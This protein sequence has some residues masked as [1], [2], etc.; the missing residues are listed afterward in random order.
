MCPSLAMSEHATASRTSL[1]LW[2]ARRWQTN[3]PKEN[4]PHSWLWWQ[5]Q[6]VTWRPG[7]PPNDKMFRPA[8]I[9]LTGLLCTT[10]IAKDVSNPDV[11]GLGVTGCTICRYQKLLPPPAFKLHVSCLMMHVP[12][13]LFGVMQTRV[14]CRVGRICNTAG[15]T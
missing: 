6:R 7:F 13:W 9:F 1:V 8:P 4:S 14:S 5:P 10:A 11:F 3:S 15:C 12:D 2:H